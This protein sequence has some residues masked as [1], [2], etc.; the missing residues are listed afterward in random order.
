ME[1]SGEN[2]SISYD[3]TTA[4]VT[5]QGSLRLF[6]TEGYEPI[7]KLFS[8]V[9]QAKLPNITLDLRNLQF[10]NSSGI[11]VVS[12]FVITVRNEQSS[13][14]TVKGSKT[15]PWQEKSLQ[16]LKRLMPTLALEI[17]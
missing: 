10:L 17:V 7:V 9:A 14:L 6:G 8:D 16:N 1:I 15:F 12:K 5:C 13:Q 4:T 11:N 3:P 2:Y